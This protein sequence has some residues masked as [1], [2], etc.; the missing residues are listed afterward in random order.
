MDGENNLNVLKSVHFINSLKAF[1]IKKKYNT[2][3]TKKK[4]K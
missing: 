3:F 1:Q 4:N 2:I